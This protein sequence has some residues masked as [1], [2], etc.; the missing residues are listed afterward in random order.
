MVHHNR[1]RTPA[2]AI[3]AAIRTRIVELYQGTYRGANASHFSELLAEHEAV[4]ISPSTALRIL[5]EAGAL[6][7]VLK[8]RPKRHAPRLR[9]PQE[10]MLWQLDASPFTWLGDHCP[11]FALQAAIDDATGT[12]VG[13][14]FRPTECLE[15]YLTVMMKAVTRYGVPEAVYTDRHSMFQPVCARLTIEQEL[16]G[17]APTLSQFGRALSGLG[18]AHLKATTPQAKGRVE[19]LWQT[20]QDRLVIELRI[21][22][23][24][25]IDEAN[26]I[27]DELI[28]RHNKRFSTHVDAS[29]Y[30]PAPHPVTLARVLAFTESRSLS[31]A[32]TVSFE[33]QVYTV[34]APGLV[35]P[36][37]SMRVFVIRTLRGE[38]LVSLGGTCFPLQPTTPKPKETPLSTAPKPAHAPRVPGKGSPWRQAMRRDY[39]RHQA[40]LADPNRERDALMAKYDATRPL[41]RPR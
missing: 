14:V 19:R 21:R 6:P 17:D 18:I 8:R 32:G 11:P 29:A 37:R 39:L 36:K 22:N 2:H 26:G 30:R 35:L 40:E 16:A 25:T 4:F 13:G 12:V 31:P 3:P 41:P 15:G 5:K 1:G 34:T 20:F 10:G 27:L 38:L 33:G 7:K 9:R 28:A 23:I 24:T